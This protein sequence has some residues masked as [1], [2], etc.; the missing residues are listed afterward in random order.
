M[1]QSRYTAAD[2]KANGE[3]RLP[4][5]VRQI[6]H[7]GGKGGRVGLMIQGTRV[8]L[9]PTTPTSKSALSDQE[10]AFLAD[11]SK[12]GVGK[13]TFRTKDAALQYLWGL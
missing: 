5:R 1:T 3:L 4:K 8:L 6:L 11:V 2:V 10:I 7:V 12:R 9:T 13:R